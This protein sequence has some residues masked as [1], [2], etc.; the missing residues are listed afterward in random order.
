LAGAFGLSESPRVSDRR[1][2]RGDR[3]FSDLTHSL[4]AKGF[5]CCH[6]TCS[7]NNHQKHNMLDFVS[8]SFQSSA[9]GKYGDTAMSATDTMDDP[10]I[11]PATEKQI[12]FAR[13]VAS[14]NQVVLPWEVQ[15]DRRA[16]SRWIDAQAQKPA[17]APDHPTSKQVAF[18]E[19]LARAK[20]RAVPDECFRS[21]ALM[22]RW[23]DSNRF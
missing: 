14:Q 2:E 1:A 4:I 21:R 12:M 19:R 7:V 16:L 15:Q 13:R 22:S 8:R 20:R 10:I 3:H 23:I 17:S 9:I 5:C 11:L 6:T 18:A